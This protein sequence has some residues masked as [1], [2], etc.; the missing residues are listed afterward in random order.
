MGRFQTPLQR[1]RYPWQGRIL[2]DGQIQ[3]SSLQV[4]VESARG[5]RAS[6]GQIERHPARA[7][8][9]DAGMAGI[10]LGGMWPK[11]VNRKGS[12]T[13]KEAAC[14]VMFTLTGATRSLD[15]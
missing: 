1:G 14:G 11:K 3:A 5:S 2:A 15:G 7:Q 13:E 10:G 4:A 12:Q 9:N 8:A 6:R